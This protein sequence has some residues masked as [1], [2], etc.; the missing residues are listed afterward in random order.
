MRIMKRTRGF[1]LIELLVVIA[2]I[3]ILAAL[4]LPALSR[5]KRKAR[6]AAC[7]SNLK[8]MS[9]AEN[10]YLVDYSGAMFPYPSG[11]DVWLDVLR[12]EYASVD[13]VRLCPLTQNPAAPRANAGTYN[14]T[15]FWSAANDPN[16]YGSY[17][18]NGWFY[19]EGWPA[20]F[21]INENEA[22]NKD[23]LVPYPALTPVFAD[24]IWPDCWPE[25]ND[26]PWPDLQTGTEADVSGG[27]A[28]L[29]RL[30]IAR[31]GPNLPDAVPTFVVTS[32]PL[33]GGINIA[34]I[35]GHVQNVS[36]ENLWN[37]YWN[38]DWVVPNPRPP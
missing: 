7:L 13:A 22:F 32:H 19:A 14:T 23:S 6:D 4:L 33:P 20:S 25:P 12:P 21:G 37:F 1:T 2:I 11:T 34:F 5:A 29:D 10:L 18:L 17:T 16:A 3:A 27:P 28:G 38:N 15:W 35:D 9:L 30:M 26:Q 36:L 24:G 31:H 8:Q